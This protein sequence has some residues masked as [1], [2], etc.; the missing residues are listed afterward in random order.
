[1]R[2]AKDYQKLVKGYCLSFS[3]LK[4]VKPNLFNKFIELKGLLNKHGA[5]FSELIRN[6]KIDFIN[7]NDTKEADSPKVLT[8]DKIL[9]KEVC[10][11]S[12]SPGNEYSLEILYEK[13]SI[14]GVKKIFC[15]IYPR[16]LDEIKNNIVCDVF[17][18]STL[19]ENNVVK[20]VFN[21]IA[22]I[23]ED[24]FVVFKQDVDKPNSVKDAF[25]IELS[26]LSEITEDLSNEF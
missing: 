16:T 21:Y 8:F 2:T 25:E 1:M 20:Q 11:I 18:I 14:V 9:Y 19:D 15:E 24:C 7:E 10:A 3:L 22:G 17:R 13:H 23:A 5:H 12:Y 6:L 4:Q 26:K